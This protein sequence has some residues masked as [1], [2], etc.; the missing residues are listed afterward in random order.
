[1]PQV[2]IDSHQTRVL[3]DSY[4]TMPK[5]MHDKIHHFWITSN[6]HFTKQIHLFSNQKLF[7]CY[8]LMI[9]CIQNSCVFF[10][11]SEFLVSQHRLHTPR[12]FYGL[13][14]LQLSLT[15]INGS[16]TREGVYP[17]LLLPDTSFLYHII[18]PCDSVGLRHTS[19]SPPNQTPNVVLIFQPCTH[20]HSMRCPHAY[21]MQCA[22]ACY[23]MPH[24]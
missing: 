10:M 19:P 9:I 21:E 5:P 14:P 7:E 13:S 2:L 23:I 18:Q 20:T 17:C 8:T 15:I 24:V 22:I 16:F 3:T 6:D 4:H 12:Y 11:G 1:M